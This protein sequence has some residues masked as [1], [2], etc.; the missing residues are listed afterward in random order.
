VDRSLRRL[1][2]LLV[3]MGA[4]LGA[5]LG[6]SLALIVEHAETGRAGPGRERTAVLAASPQS[7]KS[8][9]SRAASTQDP[10]N[11]NNPSANPRPLAHSADRTNQRDGKADKNGEGRRDKPG[12]G[13]DKPGKS[14]GK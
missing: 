13:K 3:I 14:K 7:S 11:G 12:R 2:Q 9:A 4:V 8:P 6:V 1:G 10:G 5:A